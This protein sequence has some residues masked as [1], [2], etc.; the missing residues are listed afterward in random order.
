[1]QRA[2]H[3]QAI[4]DMQVCLLRCRVKGETIDVRD[5]PTSLRYHYSRDEQQ[6][7]HIQECVERQTR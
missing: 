4:P 6:S 7:W 2:I 1:M 3:A 5:T